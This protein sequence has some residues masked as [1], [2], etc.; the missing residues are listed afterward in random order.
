MDIKGFA[1]PLKDSLEIRGALSFNSSGNVVFNAP[2]GTSGFFGK[3]IQVPGGILGIDFPIPGNAVTATAQLAGP[4]SSLRI[5]PGDLTLSMPMK[6]ALSNP[7]I[8]P[9]CQIG[10]DS[11]PANV[12]LIIGTTSPPAPNR[13]ITGRLG[14]ATLVSDYE[15]QWRGN[16]NV[17]NS[18]SIPGASNCGINLGLINAVI[19]AKLKLPSAAGNNSLRVVNNVGLNVAP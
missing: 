2:R 17:D 7:I 14:D 19:N 11:A 9:W 3:P 8:G 18:F 10:T 5:D 1:V 12:R 6:L 16:E 15:V 13:P 4:P